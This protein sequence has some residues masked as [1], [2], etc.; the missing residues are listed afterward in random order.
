[1]SLPN[2]VLTWPHP[3]MITAASSHASNAAST[4]WR[5]S[6]TILASVV[7]VRATTVP[8]MTTYHLKESFLKAAVDDD[9]DPELRFNSD[10][11][12]RQGQLRELLD[13]LPNDLKTFRS[14]EWFVS[15]FM[16]GDSDCDDNQG[17]DNR[18]G[19]NQCEDSDE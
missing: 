4:T 1:M 2:S 16:D 14:R 5:I 8:R 12:I 13:I 18:G 19:N 17:G 11:D 9:Y 10:D 6:P 3:L 7:A 15:A